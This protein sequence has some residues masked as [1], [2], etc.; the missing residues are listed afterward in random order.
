MDNDL[1][2]DIALPRKARLFRIPQEFYTGELIR[3]TTR[4]LSTEDNNVYFELVFGD[5]R[6]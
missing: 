4:F 3:F 5:S 2:L 1:P 6:Y